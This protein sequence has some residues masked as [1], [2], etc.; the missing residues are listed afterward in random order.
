MSDIPE[1]EGNDLPIKKTRKIN[2]NGKKRGPKPK[3]VNK[4]IRVREVPDVPDEPGEL[5]YE[6]N[7]QVKSEQE[8]CE[9]SEV[10][11]MEV[12]DEPRAFPLNNGVNTPI[13]VIRGHKVIIPSNYLKTLDEINSIQLLRH[14]PINNGSDFREY[15]VPL[16][17]FPYMVHRTGLT[18][19][20]YRE[21]LDKFKTMK[22][23]WD[24][25][26]NQSR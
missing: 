15:H 19:R 3:P 17:K 20:D 23:P 1:Q 4:K 22:D 14:E 12:T 6:D 9:Y 13:W 7:S 24:K 21:M 25:A 8:I 18:Y 11:I 10:T 5:S 26:T 2:P 16:M